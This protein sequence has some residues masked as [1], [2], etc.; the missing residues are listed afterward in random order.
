V[1]FKESTALIDSVSKLRALINH[2]KNRKQDIKVVY[3]TKVEK[4]ADMEQT[5]IQKEELVQAKG[6][7]IENL[8]G[9]VS[10]ANEKIA[11]LSAM[12]AQLQNQID[13]VKA[14]KGNSSAFCSNL[15]ITDVN[16]NLLSNSMKKTAKNIGIIELNF[17]IN[18]NSMIPKG[19]KTLYVCVTNSDD[20]NILRDSD[21]DL[22]KTINGYDLFY[23]LKEEFDYST[24]KQRFSLE[25]QKGDRELFPGTYKIGFFIDNA[26]AGIG[27]FNLNE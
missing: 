7:E 2:F 27:E 25:W 8:E 12:I 1:V 17:T 22:F 6:K 21:E 5:L 11:N 18:G 15:A 4:D 19:T 20:K 26:L 13:S 3:K 23:T 9:E 24:E 16:V 14:I 10:K